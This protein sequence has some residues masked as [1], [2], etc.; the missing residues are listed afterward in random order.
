MAALNPATR[1]ATWDERRRVG[2]PHQPQQAAIGQI[3]HVVTYHV[4]AGAGLAVAADGA[5]NQ[6][7]VELAQR[8]VIHAQAGSHAGPEAF[9]HHVRC[10]RQLVKGKRSGPGVIP[11]IE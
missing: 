10:A 4:A 6:A 11:P 8:L 7:R 2:R 9:Q 3:V 1:S 5:I